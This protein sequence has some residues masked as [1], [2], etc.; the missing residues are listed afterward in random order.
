MSTVDVLIFFSYFVGVVIFATTIAARSKTKSASDYF[1]ASK[2]L[3]WYVVGASFI[4]SNISTEHFIGMVGWGFLY[5]MAVANWEWGNVAT[6]TL[7]IWVFLPFYMRGKVA[8]MPEFLERRF[9]NFC[10]Y[11]YAVV[12]IVGL[13]FAMLGGVLFAGAKAVS[14]FYPELPVLWAI[15]LLAVASG[16]YTVYG[17]LLAAVWADVLQYTLLMTAGIVVTVFGLY[18]V[19][20][21]NV[22]FSELP[23]KFI[24]FHPPSH[25]MIPWTGIVLGIF[26]VGVWYNCANQFMIQRC[27]GAR[28]EWDARMGIVM[29]G[30]S[31]AVLPLIVV[32][33]GIIAFYLF[34]DRISDGDQSW[35]FLV[36]QFLPSGLVGLVLAGLASAI[37][38]TLSAI[39]NS[40]STIFTLDLYRAI[41]R[42]AADD[43][44]LHMVGRISAAAAMLIGVLVATVA[45]SAKGVTV[46]GLIQQ[47]FFYIAP[48]ISAVFLAGI[49]WPGATSAAA[50][51]T[52]IAGFT[53]LLP[54]VV[55]V[56][57]PGFAFLQPYDNFMHHTFTVFVLSVILLV[58][59][60][61][62]TKPKSRRE[63]EG[64]IWTRSAFGI[65]ADEK[66]RYRGIRSLPLWWAV[67]VLIIVRLYVYTNSRGA[68]T[69]V[70]E[71][72]ELEYSIPDSAT[73]GLQARQELEDFNLWTGS[74]QVLFTPG[75]PGDAITFRLPIDRAGRY[76]IA[77]VVT[78]GPSY[79]RFRVTLD[80]KEAQISYPVSRL[81]PQGDIEISHAKGPAFDPRRVAGKEPSAADRSSIAGAHVVQ[82]LSLGEFMLEAG[83][84]LV[85]FE[86]IDLLEA[87]SRIGVDQLII[88]PAGH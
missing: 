70:M 84:H 7:L 88:T 11:I 69:Q 72:E 14:V 39:T 27:L 10:R 53:I 66:S 77:A 82:R 46:F 87:G 40:S 37:L 45:S 83:P 41:L 33:P 85:G 31:K 24:V 15:V 29:A 2:K 25:E 73:A 34:Q 12:M 65:L 38:S 49:L 20:G 3:P 48:P 63:L 86:A 54:L 60:S 64:V 68:Q 5:G 22:L 80:G 8:T 50:T 78:R 59:V 30:F 57:F 71:A 32:V 35:P 19:G 47:V 76:R 58:V 81:T 17:G 6:F 16:I 9:N 67:M 74:G 62:F 51:I 79:G 18:Y 4:A 55:F 26:S 42:P 44:E 1:L 43:R 21:L 23:E 36:Q 28:S 61:L 56:I 13:V 52:L 75:S